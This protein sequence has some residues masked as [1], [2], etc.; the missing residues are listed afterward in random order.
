MT[1]KK[2]NAPEKTNY[3]NIPVST[4]TDAGMN[5]NS[6]DRQYLQRM[7]CMQD[8]SIEKFIIEAYKNHNETI[9]KSL[10]ETMQAQNDRMFEA[11]QTQNLLIKEIKEDI[12]SIKNRIDVIESRLDDKD[13][14]IAL[15][16]RRMTIPNIIL[17]ILGAVLIS[18][19]TFLIIHYYFLR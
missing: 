6:N 13:V 7:F 1:I 18:E 10:A 3:T 12:Q 2:E 11:L 9:C 16:E 15:L 4:K 19:L 8:E 5:L 17:I 14:R